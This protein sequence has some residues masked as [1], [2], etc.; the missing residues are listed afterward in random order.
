MLAR[1]LRNLL[2]LLAQPRFI[3]LA[4]ALRAVISRFL[5]K[6]QANIINLLGDL[7]RQQGDDRPFFRQDLN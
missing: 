2:Q 4:G 7:P 5:L 6:Q 1:R 3:G